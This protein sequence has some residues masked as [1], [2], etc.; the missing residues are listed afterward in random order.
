[1]A[2]PKATGLL[3]RTTVPAVRRNACGF[4]TLRAPEAR[5]G[6]D[7]RAARLRSDVNLDLAIENVPLIVDLPMKIVI[8]HS[9][10]SLPEG[11]CGLYGALAGYNWNVNGI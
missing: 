10:V 8:F 4:A 11:N 1:M 7:G 3:K 9:Y 5:L 2:Q 6:C